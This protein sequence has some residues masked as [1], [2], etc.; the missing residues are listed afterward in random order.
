LRSETEASCRAEE[1]DT[2]SSER[3]AL[4]GF[5]SR[6]DTHWRGQRER[7]SIDSALLYLLQRNL[8]RE[9]SSEQQG[10]VGLVTK[11]RNSRKELAITQADVW[12]DKE[13]E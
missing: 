5:V 13:D 2:L 4:S 3:S 7:S 8:L 6:R 11:V 1:E 12:G 9:E 10:A